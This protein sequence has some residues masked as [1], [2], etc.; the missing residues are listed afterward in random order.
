[1]NQA[2][3]SMHPLKS[4]FFFLSSIFI[5]YFSILNEISI[6]Q[7][8]TPPAGSPL[9]RKIHPRIF[10]AADDVPALRQRILSLYKSEFQAYVNA[11]DQAF[12]T[13]PS[14][15]PDNFIF[16]DAKNYSFLYLLDPNQMQDINFGHTREQYGRKAFEHGAAAAGMSRGDSHSSSKLESSS[17]AY[18]GLAIAVVYDWTFPLLSIDE[19]HT[20]ADGLIHLYNIRD[21]DSDPG[22]KQ[23]LS[24]KISGYIHGGCAGALAFWGD[25]LGN[26]YESKA[27]EMMNF[28]NAVFLER[29][30][31]TGD[32]IFEGPAW[33]EGASYYFLGMTNVSFMTGAASSAIGRN[34][35]Y[36]TDFLRQNVLYI[37]Y[38]ALPLKLRDNYYLSRHDTNS[39]QEVI[40]NNISRLIAISAG[41]LRTHDPE[42]SGLAKWMLREGGMGHDISQ[43]KYYDIRLDDLFSRFIWGY[44]DV[45][46]KSPSALELPLTKRLGLGQTVMKSSFDRENST[47]IIF[48]TPKYWYSPHAHKD[49]SSFT[50]YKH[51]SLALDS[52]NGKGGEDMPRGEKTREPVFHNI[53]GLYDPEKS[54]DGYNYMDF[55]FS[56]ESSAD[57]FNDQEFSWNGNNHIGKLLAFDSSTDY[58]YV[59][60]DYTRAYDESRTDL[61]RRRLLYLHG[62]DN[63]EF[64]IIHDLVDTKLEKRFLLHTAFEPIINDNVVQV[65]NNFDRA[66]GRM[67]VKFLLPKNKQILKVGGDGKWFVD[68]DWKVIDSR[69]PYVD[70]GAYWTGSYRFEIRSQENEFLTVMQI[71]NSK[72]LTSM[73]EVQNV[74]AP[75]FSGVLIQKKRLVM[76][77]NSAQRHDN[78]NYKITAQGAVSHLIVGLKSDA[79]ARIYRNGALI[80]Q[81]RTNESGVTSFKD[82]ANGE[83]A[84]GIVIGQTLSVE[85]D[86]DQI[87]ENFILGQNYPNPFT[88]AAQH[89][90]IPGNHTTIQ[91]QLAKPGEINLQ[92]FDMT[93]RLIKTLMTGRQAAGNYRVQWD[94]LNKDNTPAPAGIYLYRLQA[95]GRITNKKLTLLR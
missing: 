59:D 67:F 66:Q 88:S 46:S 65:T 23:K 36:E 86:H 60:Y 20:L 50:I 85:T 78:I 93:G 68:A 81:A 11:L 35:Y 44:K 75:N 58:D 76:L 37:L 14:S 64:V 92:I 22:V 6:A 82:D 38:N 89:R 55:D 16:M 72:A 7:D 39:I 9:A 2:V 53:L 41:I 8:Y 69:G 29:S 47:H 74:T 40:D 5:L 43:F 83:T 15:K 63:N 80:L 27:R 73:S 79:E 52:G 4:V 91:Y 1:M 62:N 61:A 90:I 26:G 34:L 57:H 42:M 24:N 13:K 19:K 87:P 48:W 30:L 95:N 32:H 51:G 94:G 25:N 77:E 21:S 33:S 54:E 12:S 3:L 10:V 31:K 17:G 18:H 71:G 84:Y 45:V 28:F 49:L 56:G 70:W